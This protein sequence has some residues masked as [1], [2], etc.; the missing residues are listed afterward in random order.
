MEDLPAFGVKLHELKCKAG[1]TQAQL[2]EHLG[3][4]GDRIIRRWEKRIACF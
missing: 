2:A 1:L 3:V 4:S